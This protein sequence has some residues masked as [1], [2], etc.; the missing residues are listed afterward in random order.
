MMTSSQKRTCALCLLFVSCTDAQAALQQPLAADCEH[1]QMTLSANTADVLRL[2]ANFS[3]H[4]FPPVGH[5]HLQLPLWCAPHDGD[6][7]LTTNSV[8]AAAL[9]QTHLLLALQLQCLVLLIRLT[10][11]N[12]LLAEATAEQNVQLAQWQLGQEL[13]ALV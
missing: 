6:R 4:S 11:A 7:G 12:E 1:L 8:Q 13:H 2:C 5:G 10:R 3:Y 9:R